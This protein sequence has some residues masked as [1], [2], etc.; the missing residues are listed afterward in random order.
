MAASI[1]VNI[2]TIRSTAT[3]F[4]YGVM[5]EFTKVYGLKESNMDLDYIQ[6]QGQKKGSGFG[7]MVDALNGLTRNKFQISRVAKQITV[8]SIRNMKIHFKRA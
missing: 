6:F 1:K 2:G 8:N 3:A 4:I 7:R 5:V